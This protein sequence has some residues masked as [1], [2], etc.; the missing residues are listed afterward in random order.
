MLPRRRRNEEL[1]GGGPRRRLGQALIVTEMALTLTLV[2]AAGLFLRSLIRLREADPRGAD[3]VLM[4]SLK[5]VRDGGVRY[6]P[7]RL[8]GLF[9]ELE[10]RVTALP[11]V[12]AVSLTS[13]KFSLA[14]PG[15]TRLGESSRVRIE[16]EDGSTVT[17]DMSVTEGVTAGFF[18][19]FGIAPS[20]GRAF[21]DM[22]QGRRVAVISEALSRDV[23]GTGNP[24]GRR[25]RVHRRRSWSEPWEVVGVVPGT[26][27][28][29]PGSRPSR[30]C[31]IPFVQPGF[32][33][34]DGDISTLLVRAD[35]SAASGLAGAV[36]REIQGLDKELPVFN[37]RTVAAELDRGRRHERLLAILSGLMGGVAALLAAI[38]LYGMIAYSISRRTREIGVRFALGAERRSVVW[39]VLRDTLGLVGIA[40]AA[41]LPL[42]WIGGRLVAA[43]LHGV[44]PHDPA[45]LLVG[46][47]LLTAVGAVAG[48]LPA[49]RAA[50][51][52][53]TVA[54]R[55][56]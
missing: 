9:P 46:L 48:W 52:V 13:G 26:A 50:A 34:Y 53:P 2:V 29:P 44:T 18:P 21:T 54:L 31:F 55:E 43:H 33:V 49:R 32:G 42:S 39:I 16:R 56:D 24:L 15:V 30:L 8:E 38:G 6:A 36:L 14:V 20:L 27:W 7:G 35:R 51:V 19:M 25:L 22:D 4:V 40:A 37:V 17:V 12:A 23:F 10:R 28:D 1:G 5:P 45:A 3:Q 47:A 11:G 41:G